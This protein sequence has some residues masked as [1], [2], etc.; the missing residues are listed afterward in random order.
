MRQKSREKFIESGTKRKHKTR[1]I[2]NWKHK[3][4]NLEYRKKLKIW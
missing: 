4:E 2:I 1:K 3:E